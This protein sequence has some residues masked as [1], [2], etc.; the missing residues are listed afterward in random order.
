MSRDRLENAG[1][2]ILIPIVFATVANENPTLLLDLF[3]Q[4]AAFHATSKVA[5]WRDTVGMLPEAISL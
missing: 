4:I 5:C 2:G 1:L 3:D